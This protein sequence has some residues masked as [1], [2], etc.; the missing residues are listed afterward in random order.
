[1]LG[2]WSAGPLKIIIEGQSY[3]LDDAVTNPKLRDVKYLIRETRG[4]DIP[5]VTP[6]SIQKMFVDLGEKMKDPK[7]DQNAWLF[8]DTVLDNLQGVM[9]LAKRKAGEDLAFDDVSVPM[10]GFSFEDDEVEPD[11][12]DI[13]DPVV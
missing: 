10:T 2:D 13:P 8:D 1:M 7:F 5:P 6:L 3:E 9:W 11:P 12:K 4:K